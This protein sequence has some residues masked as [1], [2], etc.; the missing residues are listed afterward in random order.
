MFII[1]GDDTAKSSNRLVEILKDINDKGMSVISLTADN[2]KL[3]TLRQE[4]SPS[5]LF[6][7]KNFVSLSGLLSGTKKK[8]KLKIIDFLKHTKPD[9]ILLYESKAVHPSTIR[10][11]SGAIVDNFK[12]DSNIFKFLENIRPGSGVDLTKKFEEILES[13]VDAEFIFAMLVRQVRLLINS[14]DGSGTL[15]LPAFAVTKLK[16]Q[17]NLFTMDQLLNLHK[18]IYEIELGIKTGKNNLGLKTLLHNLLLHI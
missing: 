18:N 14:K 2:L 11:F 4:L 13:D 10:Q 8:S 3:E 16:V 5:D 15:K 9:N 1:H 6:G 7:N 17:S 12:V